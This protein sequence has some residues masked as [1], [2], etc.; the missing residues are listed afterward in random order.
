M[1]SMETLF[2]KPRPLQENAARAFEVTVETTPR[3][4]LI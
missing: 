4:N 1:S 3:F 2:G